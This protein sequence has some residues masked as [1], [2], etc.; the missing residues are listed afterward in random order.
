MNGPAFTG[1]RGL[2]P[3]RTALSWQRT[4]LGL[5]ANGG[6][7]S[8]RSIITSEPQPPSLAL[9]IV[10]FVLALVVAVLG[11]RRERILART[12][13]PSSLRPAQEVMVIGW[14]V[15]LVCAGSVLVLAFTT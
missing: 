5:L 6:L 13:V 1:Q 9:A 12:T 4:T 8:L 11:W 14:L 2:Q 7:F 10:L 15:A 3:E